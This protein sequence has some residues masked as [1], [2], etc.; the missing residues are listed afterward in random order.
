MNGGTGTPREY[1]VAYGGVRTHLSAEA[2]R[3]GYTYI[4]L[5]LDPN[6]QEVVCPPSNNYFVY[7]NTTLYA[8]WK[9]L[10][11]YAVTLDLNGGNGAIPKSIKTYKGNKVQ[12]ATEIPRRIGYK[13]LGWNSTPTLGYATKYNFGD[14]Y[15]VN[16]DAV[17]Y[18][19]WQ[20][21]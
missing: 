12:I 5:G 1:Q 11:I 8:I 7:D 9:P 17:L 13:F 16:N 6:S 15:W 18:A 4:G 10:P 2:T 3:E 21:E 19:V 20:K 14:D